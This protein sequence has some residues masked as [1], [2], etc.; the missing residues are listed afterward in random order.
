MPGDRE[1]TII[2]IH[3]DYAAAGH[4]RLPIE[5]KN[6]GMNARTNLGAQMNEDEVTSS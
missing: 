1:R 6:F 5:A 4:V 3:T 2:N